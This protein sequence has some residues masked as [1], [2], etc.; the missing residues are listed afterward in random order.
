MSGIS[1]LDLFN[2][3]YETRFSGR[4]F[5]V[6]IRGE[7]F[8]KHNSNY[9][10]YT[11]N[12][13][14]ELYSKIAIKIDKE[15]TELIDLSIYDSRRLC[16]VP[17]SLAI[18]DDNIYV[19]HPFISKSEIQHFNIDDVELNNYSYDIRSRGSPVFNGQGNVNRLIEWVNR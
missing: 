10:P 18:F 4:G 5:H 7:R 17:Y 14:Y 8:R 12:N 11:E 15:I 6:I 13:I 19:C 9:L 3:P 16:K 2:C 1:L